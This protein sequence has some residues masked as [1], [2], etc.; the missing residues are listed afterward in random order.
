M[1]KNSR[2]TYGSLTKIFHWTMALIVIGLLLLGFYLDEL[3][4]SANQFTLLKLHKSFGLLL[5]WL[6]ALRIIWHRLS[7]KP[8]SLSTHAKWEKILAKTVHIFLYAALIGMP[9]SGWIMSMSGGYPVAFFGIEIP[10]LMDK[11]SQINDISWL[12]HQ[13]LANALIAGISLHAI[14]A[15]KHHFIDKDSTLNRMVFN[16]KRLFVFIV[17]AIFIVFI[18]GLIRVLIF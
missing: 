7:K 17:I 18:G 5:L 9:L 10:A 8:V 15:F 13:Y 1:F 14:G 6:V 11:N 4:Y 3:S 2:Y 12:I 16:P